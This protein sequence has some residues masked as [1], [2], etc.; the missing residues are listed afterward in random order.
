MTVSHRKRS[1]ESFIFTY[2]LMNYS[3]VFQGYINV[4]LTPVAAVSVQLFSGDIELHVNGPIWISLS[5]PDTFGLL[6]SSVV[7]AWFFNGTTGE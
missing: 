4:Q 2:S 7:P 5:V 6:N 3:S 1:I